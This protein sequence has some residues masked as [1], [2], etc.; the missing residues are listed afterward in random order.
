[1]SLITR[2]VCGEKDT[3]ER[4]GYVC[5]VIVLPTATCVFVCACEWVC[6]MG[7]SV[8]PVLLGWMA[9]RWACSVWLV[10]LNAVPCWKIP[11]ASP[12]HR[13]PG[14]CVCHHDLWP[15][16]PAWQQE[17]RR[18]LRCWNWWSPGGRCNP[19]IRSLS[20]SFSVSLGHSLCSAISL[21]HL[22]KTCYMCV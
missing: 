10:I 22:D 9:G 14:S 15:L 1:M 12:P 4:M 20:F 19:S 11:E 21:I 7:M 13:A 5:K 2:I 8:F 18:C 6:L 3:C 17:C 16:R